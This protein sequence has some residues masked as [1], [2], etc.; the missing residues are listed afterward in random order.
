MA[1]S[2]PVGMPDFIFESKEL[3]DAYAKRVLTPSQLKAANSS[4]QEINSAFLN[5]PQG[6][7]FYYSHTAPET[8]TSPISF[9]AHFNPQMKHDSAYFGALSALTSC[10]ERNQDNEDACS[11]EM[12]NL[13]KS[14]FE[15]E[16]LYHNVNKRF[17]MGLLNVKK[18]E[19]P[20]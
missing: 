20:F 8:A 3:A 17:Y 19:A 1:H 6:L 5:G 2:L 15:G 11:N 13:R 10:V 16:L 4:S 14:A 9:A 12:R 18:G 7:S